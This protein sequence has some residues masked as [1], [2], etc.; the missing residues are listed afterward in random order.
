MGRE[1]Q[2]RG[3]VFVGRPAAHI[4]SYFREKPQRIVG[5]D[6]VNLR[7]IR[8]CELME[9][10]TDVKSWCVLVGLLATTRGRKR[11]RRWGRGGSQPREVRF[12]GR[13]AGGQLPLI[14]IEE[15]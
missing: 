9:R 1:R 14:R 2:P 13:I 12:D 6:A 5:A 4:G 8:A 11:C 10:C 15:L 3:E 7:E